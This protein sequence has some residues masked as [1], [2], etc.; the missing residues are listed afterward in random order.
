VHEVTSTVD[1][2]SSPFLGVPVMVR[3]RRFSPMPP[4]GPWQALHL[5]QAPTFALQEHF[6]TVQDA[7]FVKVLGHLPPQAAG[8]LIT[9]VFCLVPAPQFVEHR[10]HSVQ[11]DIL[12]FDGQQLPAQTCASDDGPHSF[13]P[14]LGL[15]AIFRVRLRVPL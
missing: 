7:D 4:L 13:P 8:V 11:S 5:D 1:G 12:Q 10:P 9:L 14:L 6:D 2:H 3:E 15:T